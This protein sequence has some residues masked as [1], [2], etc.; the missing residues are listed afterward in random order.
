MMYLAQAPSWKM[1]IR[2][3][4]ALMRRTA[5]LTATRRSAVYRHS[6]SDQTHKFEDEHFSAKLHPKCDQAQPLSI[7]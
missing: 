3:I 7:N 5:I 6:D 2:G 1:R 4:L